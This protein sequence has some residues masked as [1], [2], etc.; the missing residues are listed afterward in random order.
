MFFDDIELSQDDLDEI[1][2]I[3][4]SCQ[5]KRSFS[6]TDSEEESLAVP[7]S[8]KR[9]RILSDSES[10]DEQCFSSA[11]PSTSGALLNDVWSIS[12]GN[13]PKIIPYTESP[14]L[15][16]IQLRHLMA[17]FDPPDFYSL[18]VPDTVFEDIVPISNELICRTNNL[19]GWIKT[20]LKNSQ[21][22]AY[23]RQ[24]DKKILCSYSVDG[25][26]EIT[27]SCRLLVYRSDVSTRFRKKCHDSKQI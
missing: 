6:A 4:L 17:N 11:R 3:E 7:R 20:S 16:P 13:Q 12:T 18:L 2:K 21:M 14:G 23:R 10:N 22:G 5:R 24:R 9:R 19:K 1:N 27:I 15:K 25:V 8:R 26:S